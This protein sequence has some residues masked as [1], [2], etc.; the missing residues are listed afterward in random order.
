[1]WEVWYR[2]GR[3]RVRCCGDVND[4]FPRTRQSV[5]VVVLSE[6][7]TSRK[8]SRRDSSCRRVSFRRPRLNPNPE[9]TRHRPSKPRCS[10][11]HDVP[12]VSSLPFSRALFVGTCPARVDSASLSFSNGEGR[13]KPRDESGARTAFADGNVAAGIHTKLVSRRGVS[14]ASVFVRRRRVSS[15]SRLVVR[16]P[17]AKLDVPPEQPRGNNRR[18]AFVERRARDDRLV[19]RS[20]VPHLR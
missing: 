7:D 10:S 3:R 6:G 1:M 4:A 8:G 14:A 13:G 16:T 2:K 12:R 20:S 11:C 17:G 9:P 18:D 19:R 15:S 5:T